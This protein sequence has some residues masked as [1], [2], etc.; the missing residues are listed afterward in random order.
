MH[1]HVRSKRKTCTGNT[2]C[3]QI[4]TKK[5]NNT[6]SYW[7]FFKNYD[8]NCSKKI[9]CTDSIL[10]PNGIVFALVGRAT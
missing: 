8:P 6:N 2:K 5:I 7:I 10:I 9:F 1:I 4:N 3:I